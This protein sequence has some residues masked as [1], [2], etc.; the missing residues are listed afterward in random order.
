MIKQTVK[1]GKLKM[2]I[3]QLA[4]HLALDEEEYQ[5]LIGLFIE[6]ACLTLTDFSPL[7]K[8]EVQRKLSMPPIL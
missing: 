4:E 1:R 8:K 3:R 5:Q 7:L 6:T 2:G